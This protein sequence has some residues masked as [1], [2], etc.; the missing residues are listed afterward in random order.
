MRRDLAKE[1]ANYPLD[2]FKEAAAHLRRPFTA[3][4]TRWKIQ[5][6][7]GNPPTRGMVVSFIDARLVVERFNLVVPHLWWDEYERLDGKRL[8]CRLT[9]DGIT[10]QDVGQGPEASSKDAFSDALKRAAVKFGIGVSLYALRQTWLDVGEGK[11]KLERVTRGNKHSLRI[12]PST[13]DYLRNIYSMWLDTDRG[14]IFGEPLDHGDP[15]EGSVGDLAEAEE[16]EQLAI[17][18]GEPF[19]APRAEEQKRQINDLYAELRG[20]DGRKL[21]KG[22]FDAMLASAEGS[23]EQLATVENYLRELLEAAS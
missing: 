17:D 9:V 23:N 4:A 7:S 2:S 19:D 16:G 1:E 13:D 8:L 10:R 14:R 5:Q 22:K 11:N 18:N 15:E 21:H 6:Q 3:G 12:P 20:I